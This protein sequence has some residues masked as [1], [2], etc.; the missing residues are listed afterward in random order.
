MYEKADTLTLQ[1]TFWRLLACSMLVN[2]ADLATCQGD[3]YELP[4]AN[5]L[6]IIAAYPARGPSGSS[7]SFA[8]AKAVSCRMLQHA[9]IHDRPRIYQCDRL[10]GLGRTRVHKM[11]QASHHSCSAHA[12]AAPCVPLR[13]DTDVSVPH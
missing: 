8:V 10:F 1:G 2:L 9:R 6:V 4:S 13:K 3:E 7:A 5:E 12:V 11:L